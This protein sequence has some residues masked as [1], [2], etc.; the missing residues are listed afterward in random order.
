LF[1]ILTLSPI[2][3]SG[4]ITTFWPMLQRR[5]MRAPVITCVKCHSLVSSPI[6]QP[7]ST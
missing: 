2:T 6:A 1:W 4:E 3:T 5:P 7:S